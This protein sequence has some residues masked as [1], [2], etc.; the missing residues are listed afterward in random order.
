MLNLKVK[1]GAKYLSIVKSSEDRGKIDFEN[2]DRV[3]HELLK[4]V[5]ENNSGCLVTESTYAFEDNDI[6]RTDSMRQ[7]ESADGRTTTYVLPNEKW[8]EV[9]L[10]KIATS[11]QFELSELWM[12][13]DLD[14]SAAQK[15]TRKDAEELWLF[16]DQLNSLDFN[17]DQFDQH[18]QMIG[19]L[20][21]GDQLLWT[22]PAPEKVDSILQNIKELDLK[23]D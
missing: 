5:F 18:I 7:V 20:A 9:D 2:W 6:E 1:S 14:S 19:C 15:M 12:R 17:Y 16:A 10:R 23:I 4:A 22:N 8:T 21:D 3:K 11:S 13:P